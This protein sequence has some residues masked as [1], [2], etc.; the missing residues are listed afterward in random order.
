M[1]TIENEFFENHHWS[2][3]QKVI[4]IFKGRNR[5]WVKKSTVATYL[6]HMDIWSGM[7]LVNKIISLV[8][9]TVFVFFTI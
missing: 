5:Q 6:T 3:S 9:I 1:D 4:P 8:I 2:Y 7:Y